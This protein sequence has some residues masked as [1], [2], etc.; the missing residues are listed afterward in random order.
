[1]QRVGSPISR[2]LST[3]GQ[4]W[5][6]LGVTSEHGKMNWGQMFMLYTKVSILTDMRAILIVILT[7][8]TVILF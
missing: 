2:D 7:I 1:M 5:Q 8:L 4:K 3:K 6:E